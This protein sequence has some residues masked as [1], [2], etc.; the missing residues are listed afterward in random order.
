MS[1][2]RIERKTVREWNTPGLAYL[3]ALSGIGLATAHHVHHMGVG[4]LPE[5]SISLHIFGEL[6]G[7]TI[8]GALALAVLAG[9]RNRL[10]SRRVRGATL[11]GRSQAST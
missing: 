1:F 4:D 3:G 6:F 5:H 10:A 11:R 8:A 7:A 2:G 9:I